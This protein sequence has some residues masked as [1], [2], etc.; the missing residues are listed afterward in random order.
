LKSLDHKLV[1]LIRE[2]LKKE[3]TGFDV[4]IGL[5]YLLASKEIRFNPEKKLFLG[6][7]SLDGTIRPIAG[8]LPLVREAV[9]HGFTEIFVPEKNVHEASLGGSLNVFPLQTFTDV[10]LH[11]TKKKYIDAYSPPNK[12]HKKTEIDVDFSDIKGRNKLN[13]C[14]SSLQL[15]VIMLLYMDLQARGRHYLLK[16]I[17]IYYHHYHSMPPLKSPRSIQ[18]W[19]Y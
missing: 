4:A 17:D 9:A 16:P 13:E 18:L 1:D 8:V 10:L 2:D 11:L 5:A 19:G 6:E 3:G 7:V 15:A 12:V 14:S